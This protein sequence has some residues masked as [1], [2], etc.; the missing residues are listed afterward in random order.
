MMPQNHFR[1]MLN[2][3]T[4]SRSLLSS[5]EPCGIK[6]EAT[7]TLIKSNCFLTF[8]PDL[9]QEALKINACT[10]VENSTITGS[11]SRSSKETNEKITKIQYLDTAK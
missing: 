5:T 6:I 2:L 10:L 3:E 4:S 9:N 8:K 7:P 11:H 1:R